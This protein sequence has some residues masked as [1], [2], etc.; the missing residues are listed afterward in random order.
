MMFLQKL[1]NVYKLIVI[2]DS[3]CG[4][5]VA[6]ERQLHQKGSWFPLPVSDSIRKNWCNSGHSRQKIIY[7]PQAGKVALYN[8][9]SQFDINSNTKCVKPNQ[10]GLQ[11]NTDN[12]EDSPRRLLPLNTFKADESAPI[13]RQ[14]AEF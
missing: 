7:F 2:A 3:G 5:N 10:H 14:A 13:R 12:T 6:S 8:S 4:R 1:S 9:I 11:F